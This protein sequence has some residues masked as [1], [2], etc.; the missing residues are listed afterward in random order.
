MLFANMGDFFAGSDFG[1][2]L[3][4]IKPNQWTGNPATDMNFQE[5]FPVSF[6]KSL[7]G[8]WEEFYIQP[9]KRLTLAAYFT[10]GNN[11]GLLVIQDN[12]IDILD[13][14]QNAK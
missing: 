5:Q 14:F 7:W 1:V 11:S 4:S 13:K 10:T 12:K 8:L 2:L 9:N 6:W 3:Y